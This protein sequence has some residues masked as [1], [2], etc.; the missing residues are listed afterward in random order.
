LSLTSC[1]K[2]S[3]TAKGISRQL[4]TPLLGFDL[5]L[6]LG[7]FELN[8]VAIGHLLLPV[9]RF[10]HAEFFYQHATTSPSSKLLLTLGQ[11][12]KDRRSSKIGDH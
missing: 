2:G 11:T 1:F 10:S 12:S 6:F 7:G 4:L 5:T 3:A 8:K 9:L